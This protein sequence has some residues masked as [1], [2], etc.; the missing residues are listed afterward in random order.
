MRIV[1]VESEL[2]LAQSIAA[3]LAEH[4]FETEIYSSFKDA[5]NS[6]GDAY[7]LSMSITGQSCLPIINKF[8]E[9]I[10]ILMVNYI[11]NDTV[12]EPI[13]HGAR[14]YIVKPFM[15]EDLIRKIEHHRTVCLLEKQTRFYE[16]YVTHLMG[17]VDHGLS[18]EKFPIPVI[19]QTNYQRAA[20]KLAIDVGKMLEMPLIFISLED[21][22]WEGQI[23]RLSSQ[24]LGYVIH[25]E[26]LRKKEQ[27]ELFKQ[28]KE[29]QVILTSLEPISEAPWE[30]LEIKTANKL[31]DH[32]DILTIDE[33]VQHVV[34]SLQYKLP[35]TTLS[36]KLGISRK[37]LWEK[38]KKYDLFKKK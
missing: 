2:Y 13:Q 5:M 12:G 33:Y 27:E 38:R 29:K 18:L 24:E 25:L 4:N 34:K 31:F 3:K 1:I 23:E 19:V 36:K 28:L 16:E 7:L 8:K 30:I 26:V 32:N 35:D 20:D 11:N 22:G 6:D 10:I 21:E 37:S 9:K 15:I 14:D 17:E